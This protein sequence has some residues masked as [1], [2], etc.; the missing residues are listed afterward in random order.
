M[1]NIRL[2][3]LP[4]YIVVESDFTYLHCGKGFLLFLF[5]VADFLALII[6]SSR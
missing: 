3:I 4:T 1:R 5:V 6:G 2:L